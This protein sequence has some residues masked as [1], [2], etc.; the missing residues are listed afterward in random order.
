MKYIKLYKQCAEC[1]SNITLMTSCRGKD[2]EVLT[3]NYL[4]ERYLSCGLHVYD[5]VF[6]LAK[7]LSMKDE[8][9]LKIGSN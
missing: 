9:M 4:V 1:G 3:N 8:V 5:Y 6:S 7:V 2:D